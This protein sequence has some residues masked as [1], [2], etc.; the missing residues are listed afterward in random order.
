MLITG[1]SIS[2]S[3]LSLNGGHLAFLQAQNIGVEELDDR[4]ILY[5]KPA[6]YTDNKETICHLKGLLTR[7][8]ADD[9][10]DAYSDDFGKHIIPS[11]E[12]VRP[13]IKIKNDHL[14]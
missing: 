3:N 10:Y 12:K 2:K 4:Y 13:L 11:R 7:I 5:Y 6:P 1:I 14:Q 9:I 8:R